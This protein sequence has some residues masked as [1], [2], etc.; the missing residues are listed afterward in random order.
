[1]WTTAFGAVG[2]CEKRMQ[3]TQWGPS[4]GGVVAAGVL[5]VAMAIAAVTLVTDPPGRLL[6]G[7]AAAGLIVFAI[8]SWRARPKLA[9]TGG[10]LVYRGWWGARKLTK[11]DITRI[12]ITEFRRIGRKMRLLELDT[13]DGRLLVLSRWDLGTDP[14]HVLDAL[15]DAGYAPGAGSGDF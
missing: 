15:T 3:Q 8:M 10:A 14:L 6:I 4:A 9:I 1:M 2:G 7:V 12:R 11:A 13:T 5:G